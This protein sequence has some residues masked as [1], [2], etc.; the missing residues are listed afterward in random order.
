MR[1]YKFFVYIITNRR[2]GTLYTGLTNDIQRRILEHKKGVN[3]GFS[4]RYSL[5]M[6]VYFEEH[7]YINNARDRERQIKAWKREWKI[8]MIEKENPEWE[9][10]ASNWYYPFELE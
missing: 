6:L 3:E 2:N 7:K 4:K 5:G 1:D 9:D 10:L 8:K